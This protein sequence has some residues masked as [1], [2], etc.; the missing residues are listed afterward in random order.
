MSYID[1]VQCAIDVPPPQTAE[2]VCMTHA[3]LQVYMR[4]MDKPR[5]RQSSCDATVLDEAIKVYFKHQPYWNLFGM[6]S[7]EDVNGFIACVQQA[8][9]KIGKAATKSSLND[10][11]D[12]L[13]NDDE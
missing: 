1:A 6:M 2:S 4:S 9:T 13:S 10:D 3:E 8:H 11:A 12:M 5:T 7:L